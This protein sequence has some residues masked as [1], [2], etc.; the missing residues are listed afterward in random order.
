MREIW[1]MQLRFGNRNHSR[2]RRLMTHPRFRAA[3]DFLLLRAQTGDPS[4]AEL[5]EWW[6][7]AQ[8]GADLP[9]VP[10]SA[11]SDAGEAGADAP[12]RKRS[13]RRGGRR[14]RPDAAPAAPAG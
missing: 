11:E 14:N 5:A 13:R 6:T 8:R 10:E 7:A 4:L 12:A 3:Y 9:P 2:A 1:E